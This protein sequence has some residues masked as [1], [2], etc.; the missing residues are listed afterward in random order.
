VPADPD[1]ATK[2]GVFYSLADCDIS[3]ALLIDL[4]EGVGDFIPL[5]AVSS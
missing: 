3:W 4:T 2:E 1:P 5:F